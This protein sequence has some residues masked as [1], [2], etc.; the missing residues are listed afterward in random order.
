MLEALEP[1]YWNLGCGHPN[2]VLTT[3]AEACLWVTFVL[4][5]VIPWTE[6]LKKGE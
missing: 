5:H 4:S 6:A 2:G 3:G 1:R